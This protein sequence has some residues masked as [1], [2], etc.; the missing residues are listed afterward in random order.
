[1]NTEKT[2]G[3][4]VCIYTANFALPYRALAMKFWWFT[5]LS[6][7]PTCI[8]LTGYIKNERNAEGCVKPLKSLNLGRL[9]GFKSLTS[10]NKM[11]ERL[12]PDLIN[13]TRKMD[14]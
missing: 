8:I 5:R 7:P 4:F 9:N 3:L 14:K 6:V 11:L 12:Y 13:C 10:R 1:M 2:I